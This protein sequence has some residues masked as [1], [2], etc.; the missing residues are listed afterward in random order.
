MISIIGAGKWGIALH[1][2]IS[3][4]YKCKITS[5]TKRNISDFVSFDEAINSKYIIFAISAQHTQSWLKEHFINKNQNILVASKG[6][7]AKSGKF[8]NEIFKVFMKEENLAFLSGP[9]F[10]KE[11]LEELPTAVVI[12][13]KNENLANEFSKF[14]PSFIKTYISDDIIG[15]EICG[16]YKNVLAIAGGISDGLNLGNNARAALMARGLVEMFRFGKK[17]DAKIETFLSLSGAGDLFLTA[18]SPLSRNY[19][20]GYLLSKGKNLTQALDEI[21]EV[22]EGVYTS[23]A[24]AFLAKK[25]D[26]YTPIASEVKNIIDGKNPKDSLNDLLKKEK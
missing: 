4:N 11:V 26:I 2:A 10:A 6:I 18:S 15:A 23:Q 5:R 3:K 14:F 9:S 24:I 12:N 17:F 1:K 25:Y 7:D 21:K 13:S 22:A 16:S 19:R 20:V 8:L